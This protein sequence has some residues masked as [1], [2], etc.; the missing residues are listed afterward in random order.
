MIDFVNH[1]S[2]ESSAEVKKPRRKSSDTAGIPKVDRL[3]RH[4]VEAEQ[5]VLGCILLS[6]PDCLGE[7][8][9]KLKPG[10][11]AFYDLRHQTL[12]QVLTE[13]Y[14]EKLGIDLITLQQRLKNKQQIENAGGLG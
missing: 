11:L 13:M 5:G 9:E 10:R 8:I 7:C 6:P 2:G 14:D 12:F 1:D 3:P 4:S